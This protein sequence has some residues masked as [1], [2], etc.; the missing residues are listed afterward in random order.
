VSVNI[1]VEGHGP[2]H[3]FVWTAAAVKWADTVGPI[4]RAALKVM[5]PVG[6]GPRAGRLRTSIRYERRTTAGSGVTATFTAYTPYARYVIDGTKPH[7]IRP[8]AARYLHFQ[9]NGRDRFVGPRGSSARSAYVMHPG[10]RANK[11]N[12]RAF[13]AIG[14]EI[15]RIYQVIMSEAM[16]GTP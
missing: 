15:R 10:T 8:V 16:G 1:T 11:F 9:Q 13:E 12:E 3:P 7:I 6:K 14:P 5:A 4:A 2:D